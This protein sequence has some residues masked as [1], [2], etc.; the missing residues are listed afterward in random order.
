MNLHEKNPVRKVGA[1]KYFRNWRK[2]IEATEILVSLLSALIAGAVG[3]AGNLLFANLSKQIS[4]P[5]GLFIVLLIA[6]SALAAL[7]VLFF[8]SFRILKSREEQ[9]N[10]TYKTIRENNKSFFEKLQKDIDKLT[11]VKSNLKEGATVEQTR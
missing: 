11:L 9:R 3:L 6:A 7:A 4:M 2:Y 1:T 5:S 8:L 10:S